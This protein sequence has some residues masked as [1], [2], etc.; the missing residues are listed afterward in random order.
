MFKYNFCRISGFLIIQGSLKD[1]IFKPSSQELSKCRL[2][3]GKVPLVSG[4]LYFSSRATETLLSF[5][6]MSPLDACTYLGVD[7]GSKAI[8]VCFCFCFTSTHTVYQCGFP[9]SNCFRYRSSSTFCCRCVV[10]SASRT[11]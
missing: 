5:H 10:T 8:Q 4:V 3:S 6:T 11:S 7:S 1:V 9:Y 2:I